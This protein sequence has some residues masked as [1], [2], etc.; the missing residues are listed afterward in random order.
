LLH[1]VF[2]KFKNNS[3]IIIFGDFNARIGA[4]NSYQHKIRGQ[5]IEG[6]TND[7]GNFLLNFC[8]SN[9]LCIANSFFKKDTYDTFFFP[10]SNKGVTL[11]YCLVSLNL[12]SKIVDCG[13]D[14]T[15]DFA[16]IISDHMPVFMDMHL[17]KIETEIVKDFKL[18]KKKKALDF[19]VLKNTNDYRKDISTELM[20][21][22]ANEG[23]M[24]IENFID[25]CNQVSNK[26]LPKKSNNKCNSIW[27]KNDSNINSLL[28]SRRL[29]QLE[30]RKD[31]KNTSKKNTYYDCKRYTRKNLRWIK[32]NLL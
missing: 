5:Y 25:I 12:R 4:F 1:S 20:K 3:N 14:E 16:D 10:G 2:S 30:W 19:S 8:Y 24:N 28:L 9:D 31:K 11:D 26:C 18:F 22:V 7:N 29:A 15:R 6:D 27:F 17:N 23:N 21:R 32:S 13:V